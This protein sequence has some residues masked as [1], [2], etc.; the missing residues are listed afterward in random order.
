MFCLN[1]LP[2]P[3]PAMEVSVVVVEVSTV[4]W[5]CIAE[6]DSIESWRPHPTPWLTP[7]YSLKVWCRPRK[8]F[9]L[10]Q[11]LDPMDQ[12]LEGARFWIT[13]KKLTHTTSTLG[14]FF[15][16]SFVTWEQENEKL[17]FQCEFSLFFN[18]NFTV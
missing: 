7:A 11:K 15:N 9:P 6:L 12:G 13:I 18:R 4:L 8:C 14:I 17:N 3:F 2:P 1:F 10:R 5:I 16:S